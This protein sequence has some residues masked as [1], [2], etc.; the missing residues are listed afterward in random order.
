MAAPTLVLETGGG[1]TN[2]NSY[3]SLAEA[4]I[5]LSVRPDR[6]KTKWLAADNYQKEQV[7]IWATQLLD[8]WIL[9]P[10][11]QNTD[12]QALLFP[13]SGVVNPDGYVLGSY[14]VY[15]FVK[16]ATVE[17][18]LALLAA[19]LTSEPPRGLDSLRVGPIG[20]DFNNQE[21]KQQ[22]VIPRSVMSILAPFGCRL[23]G[24]GNAAIGSFPLERA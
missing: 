17:L 4:E 7:L 21:S 6:Y 23:R 18:A 13:R 22:R 19:D 20:L 11:V 16:R 3:A 8:E 12:E 5:I 2:S 24:V 10:G 14:Q 1:L 15:P 9:W